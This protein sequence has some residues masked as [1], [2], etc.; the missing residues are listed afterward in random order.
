MEIEQKQRLINLVRE[1]ECIYD[2]KHKEYKNNFL[3]TQLWENIGATL[4]IQG[5]RLIQTI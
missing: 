3:K 1:N 5:R 2:N 4:N